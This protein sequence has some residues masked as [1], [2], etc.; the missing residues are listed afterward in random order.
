M[1]GIVFNPAAY[2]HTSVAIADAV[3]G[4][5]I[6]TVEVHISDVNAREDF[7]RVSYIGQVAIATVAGQ[8]LLGYCQAMDILLARPGDAHES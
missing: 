2:T 1:D 4:V 6:P 8:G 3:K 5:G 7:R